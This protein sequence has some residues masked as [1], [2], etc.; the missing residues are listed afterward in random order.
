MTTLSPESL[1]YRGEAPIAECL[2]CGAC[3]TVC[4]Y[5]KCKLTPIPFFYRARLVRVSR[6]TVFA[7]SEEKFARR[8]FAWRGKETLLR[9]LDIYF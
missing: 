7:M 4:P 9:N 8:A 6:E 2:H 3:Q 5:N 1:G